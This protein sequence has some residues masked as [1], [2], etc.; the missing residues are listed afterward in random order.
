MK[1]LL[2]VS[3]ILAMLAAP[4]F[5]CTCFAVGKA[6]TVD[7]S[8]IVTH[9]DDSSGAD[10]RLWIIPG[11]THEEG[12]MR[13]LVI[14]SHNYA[15]YATWY[16]E[17]AE[18][19]YGNGMLVDQMPEASVTYQYF[20]CRYSFMNEKGVA[21]G[22]TTMSYDRSTEIGKKSYQ[23]IFGDNNGI[24]DCWNAQDIALERATTAR[25]AVEIMADLVTKYGWKDAG[26]SIDICDGNEVW[27]AEFYG[28]DLYCAFRLPDD[29]LWVGANRATIDHVEWDN[30]DWIYSPNLYTFAVENG[31]Y[32]GPKESFSPQDAYNPSTGLYGSRREWR[33]LSLAAPS[34]GLDPNDNDFPLYVTPDR[35]LSVQDIFEF[36]GDY[37]Q[38]TPYD[39]SKTAMAGPY[40]D[41]LYPQNQER[42]IN[43]FRCCYVMIANVK[44]WLPDEAKCL[45]WHGYGSADST[46]LTPLWASMNSLPEFYITGNRYEEYREDSGWWVCSGVQQLARINYQDAIKKIHA[47]RQEKLDGLYEI[48]PAVQ[49]T[50]ARLVYEGKEEQAKAYLTTFASQ[51]ATEWQETWLDLTDYLLGYYMWGNK[52]MKT[53][54]FSKYY[55]SVLA[56]AP[57]PEV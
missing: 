53:A 45:V 7:G 56:A 52:Q 39:V 37:Y 51:T 17:G 23:A 9:N 14:D 46:Y 13:D 28:K 25:E 6:A 40:G 27:I 12:E 19:D 20:H 29:A 49:Q 42:T 50:A 34:L 16:T 36:C 21:M 31:L 8:T 47:V 33:G 18:K 57:A 44:S 11:G 43:L 54:S 48:V 2:V 5:A 24:I 26:E 3:I 35:L 41:P 32:D 38:G 1:K 22:E 10:F 4:I 30:P 15:D 55:Q